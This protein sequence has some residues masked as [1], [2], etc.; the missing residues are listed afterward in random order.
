[1]S[2]GRRLAAAAVGSIDWPH[3]ESGTSVEDQY[4]GLLVSDDPIMS[5]ASVALPAIVAAPT[6]AR[7]PASAHPPRLP[8]AACHGK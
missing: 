1:M 4:V 8:S 5:A 2:L 6:H 7:R 3:R